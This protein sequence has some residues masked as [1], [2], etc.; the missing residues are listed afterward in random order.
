MSRPPLRARKRP[1]HESGVTRN[2]VSGQQTPSTALL[3]RRKQW[4]PQP[5]PC[6]L[7]PHHPLVLSAEDA[8]GSTRLICP[9]VIW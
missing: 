7:S 4:R 5:I 9:P 3:P 2:F 6:R 8:L 1:I